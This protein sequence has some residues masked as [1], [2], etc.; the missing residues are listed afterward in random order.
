MSEILSRKQEEEILRK[1]VE[2]LQE[3]SYLRMFLS[4]HLIAWFLEMM[5]YDFSTDLF[6]VYC[7]SVEEKDAQAQ[8]YQALIARN[9]ERSEHDLAEALEKLD[10]CREDFVKQ[11]K[12]TDYYRHLAKSYELAQ[13]L[14][15]TR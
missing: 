6:Q 13:E 14:G 2:G 11:I 10:T 9:S 7:E 12:V 5:A 8:E 3:G 4:D 1:F 15:Y